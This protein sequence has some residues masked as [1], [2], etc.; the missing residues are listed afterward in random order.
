MRAFLLLSALAALTTPALADFKLERMLDYPFRD[1]L[2]AAEHA[3]RIAWVRD[4]NGVR[5]VWA[6]EGPDFRPYQ[7]TSYTEDDGQEI[8]QLSFAPDGD[9]LVYVRGGNHD[10]NWQDKLA[11]DPTASPVQPQVTIWSVS[12]KGGTPTKVAEGD[13]PAISA[14]NQIAYIKGGQVW[15]A[16]LD[17]T[18]TPQRLFFDRGEDADLQWSPDGHALA[19]VSNRGDH[20]MIGIYTAKDKPIVYLAPSTGTDFLPRW[21]PDGTRVAF[22]RRQDRGGPPEPL[23]ALVPHPW[24]IWIADA[25]DG[26]GHLAWQ[27][28]DTMRGS[29]PSLRDQINLHWAAGDRLIFA[30]ALDGWSHLYSMPAGGGQTSLLT[31]GAYMV[32]HTA[33]SRDGK[34][35]FFDANWGTADGDSD[36][37]HLFRVSAAGG[38]PTAI[39]S[40]TSLEWTPV[41]AGDNEIAYIEAGSQQPPTVA[42]A[43]PDGEKAR[44]LDDGGIP[45]DFPI[46]ELVTPKPVTFRAADGTII[47]GQL[48]EQANQKRKPGIIYVHGGPPRQMLAGWH[49]FEYYSNSYAENQYL[50]NLGFAVLSVNYRLGIGYGRAF[51]QA[52]HAGAAGASEYQD[53]IAGAR[54][55]QGLKDVE[56][57][58]IGIWGG[59]YGGYLTEL[60]L[61]R[62]SDVFKAGVELHG[63]SDW[64][65]LLPARRPASPGYEQGDRKKA[66]KVAFESSPDA[67]ITKWRSPVLLIQGDDDRNVPFAQMIDLSQRLK[68]AQVDYESLV[69]PNEV[70][71]FLRHA[72]WLRADA[73]I[74]DF[75]VR[76]LAP[77]SN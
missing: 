68:R 41:V 57:H 2:V 22:V 36:R 35:I 37:R 6:A 64:S 67:S 27:S 12:L 48:F 70:H 43:R 58:R 53:V 24:S 14:E 11:P 3:D 39:T 10:A 60:A 34:T 73:A 55:L 4:L 21:S 54:Y 17:G 20:S 1:N 45:A 59:S 33:E 28:P 9:H 75:F 16:T 5:N 29:L 63:I 62:N 44:M 69:I 50:A 15:T 26:D 66:M 47:H 23:L 31:P 42:V 18:G 77:S 56:P 51:E 30:A 46:N 32:E 72:T 61:A 71:A 38:L 52:K 19:F 76:R 74:A 7:A 49:Y 8:T 65:T 40:G 25:K 13:A